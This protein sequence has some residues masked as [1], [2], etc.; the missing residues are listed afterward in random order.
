MFLYQF[1]GL[2]RVLNIQ[3][4][5]RTLQVYLDLFLLFGSTQL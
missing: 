5:S 1:T 2:L 4:P 3:K